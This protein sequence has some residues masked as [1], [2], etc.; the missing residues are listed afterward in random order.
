MKTRFIA[1]IV[2]LV[3]TL[4]FNLASI[5]AES[6][7]DTDIHVTFPE[8]IGILVLRGQQQYP[9]KELGYSLRYSDGAFIKVDVYIYDNNLFNI[10][11][12]I[13]S[14]EVAEEFDRVLSVFPAMEKMG[15]YKN[16]KELDKG[17]ISFLQGDRQFLWSRNQYSQLPGEETTYPDERISETYL[18]AKSGKFIKVRMTLIANKFKEKQKEMKDFMEELSEVLRR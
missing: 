5:H 4:F 10:G 12:G 3:C 18:T 7:K 1:F 14:Q 13:D 6:F 2:M 8:K 9:K 11:D 15:K 17:V 16:V